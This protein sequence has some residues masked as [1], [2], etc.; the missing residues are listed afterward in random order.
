[1][2]FARITLA[3]AAGLLA[4]AAQAAEPA[5]AVSRFVRSISDTTGENFPA[6]SDWALGISTRG[7]EPRVRAIQLLPRDAMDVPPLDAETDGLVRSRRTNSAGRERPD[8]EDL[9]FARSAGRTVYLVGAWREPSV[10][11]EISFEGDA[12]RWRTIGRRGELGDWE[13]LP[14]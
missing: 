10:I 7:A 11:W 12:A 1:M 2:G 5:T 8:D 3:A 14:G 4:Y 6:S 13:S 9:E